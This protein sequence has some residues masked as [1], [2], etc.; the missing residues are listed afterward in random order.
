M[1]SGTSPAGL[2]GKWENSTASAGAPAALEVEV[3]RGDDETVLRIRG[4][5]DLSTMARFSAALAVGLAGPGD[6]VI[7]LREIAFIDCSGL[8]ALR[9]AVRRASGGPD[10]CTSSRARRSVIW[11][12]CSGVGR[13]SSPTTST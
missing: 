11:F 2:P 6:L 5:V 4:E 3:C 9:R 8:E 12:R 7:D 13:M 1:S 10:G